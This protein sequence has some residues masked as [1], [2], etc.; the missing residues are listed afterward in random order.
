[1]SNAAEHNHDDYLAIT[2][3]EWLKEAKRQR[4]EYDETDP[5][6]FGPIGET[7]VTT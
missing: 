4:P 2:R 3:G 1:M 5:T 7:S 6:P